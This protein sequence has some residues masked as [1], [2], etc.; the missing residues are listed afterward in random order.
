MD[1]KGEGDPPWGTPEV[2]V[3]FGDFALDPNAEGAVLQVGA[4]PSDGY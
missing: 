1:S 2:T 4:D 3:G